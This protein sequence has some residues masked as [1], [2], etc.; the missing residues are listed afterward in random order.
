[1]KSENNK[2]NN[3]IEKS[4]E[5]KM[6]TRKLSTPQGVVTIV[7][8]LYGLVAFFNP[9]RYPILGALLK[10]EHAEFVKYDPLLGLILFAIGIVIFFRRPG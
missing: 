8:T 10:E 3:D 6:A 7:I 5:K 9:E 2:R 4:G 1:M